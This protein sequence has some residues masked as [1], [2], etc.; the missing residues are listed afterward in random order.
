[1][2]SARRETWRAVLAALVVTIG[3]GVVWAFGLRWLRSVGDS[4]IWSEDQ[5]YEDIAV[6]IDGTPVISVQSNAL[7]NNLTVSRRTLDGR[8]WP[9]EYEHW[10]GFAHLSPRNLPP[11]LLE[12]P[13]EWNEWGGRMVGGTD[14]RRPPTAWYVVRND[15]SDNHCFLAGFD[16]FSNL[17]IGY[18]G[19]QGFRATTPALA[20]QFALPATYE[21]RLNSFAASSQY[22]SW[23]IVWD[24]DLYHEGDPA[25]WLVFMVEADRMWEVDLRQRSA[26]VVLE[27]AGIISATRIKALKSTVETPPADAEAANARGTPYR[28]AAANMQE[29]FNTVQ[30]PPAGTEGDKPKYSGAIAV[31]TNDR[32]VVY[33]SPSGNVREFKLP[34]QAPN[35]WL[36]VYW[37]VP[38]QLL[39]LFDKGH[40]SGGS[41]HQ[42]MWFD[43]AGNVEREEEVKLAGWLPETP[44]KKAWRMSWL[45]PVPL[46]WLLGI[47]LG[48]PLYMLQTYG[49]TDYPTALALVSGIAWPPLIVVL[50]ISAVLAWFSL[51]LQRNYRRP[52]T[53][54]WAAFVLLLGVP[55]F[56]AYWLEHRR[57]KLESCKECDQIVPR[58]RDACAACNAPFPAPPLAGTE[59]FA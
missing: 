18:I 43:A 58:D 8:Q 14:G 12:L 7:V 25:P 29:L 38:D 41:V 26:Q 54:V 2:A 59:I 28:F 3:I 20:D 52:A 22:L 33:H 36:R 46:L 50:A 35:H 17:P 34:K 4:I 49:A 48:A 24:H 15:E 31:R 55:G 42:L 32:I 16:A 27:T 11:G 9:V 6:A 57:P 56:V 21:R 45:A 10:L 51:R 53:A 44:R 1:M 30:L 23:G 40:W 47:V 39:L 13:L 5:V 19:R 37:I